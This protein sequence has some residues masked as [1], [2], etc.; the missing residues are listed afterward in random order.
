MLVRSNNIS[1]LTI[2]KDIITQEASLKKYHLD[3]QNKI[4]DSSIDVNLKLLHP[5]LDEQYNL[6]R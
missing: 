2:L 6:A 4:N 3:I 5:K 1:A